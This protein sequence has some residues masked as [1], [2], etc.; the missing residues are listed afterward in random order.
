MLSYSGFKKQHCRFYFTFSVGKIHVIGTKCRSIPNTN[1]ITVLELFRLE[2]DKLIKALVA[3][4]TLNM[5]NKGLENFNN[6]RIKHMPENSWPPK[7]DHIVNFIASFLS[8]K[9]LSYSTVQCYLA[10]DFRFF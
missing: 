2:V 4:N 6:I 10:G 1:S 5:Y 8:S 7:V 9:V 3:P